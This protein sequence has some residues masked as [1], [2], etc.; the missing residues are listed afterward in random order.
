MGAE[1]KT[2]KIGNRIITVEKTATPGKI[3]AQ[4]GVS[5]N[6]QL[7]DANSEIVPKNSPITVRDNEVFE[8]IPSFTKG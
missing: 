4:A 3:M 2:I 5:P 6:R 7:I 8:T 1:K